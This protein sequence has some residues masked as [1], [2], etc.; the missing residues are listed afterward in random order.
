MIKLG[1][2]VI[3]GGAGFAAGYFFHQYMLAPAGY[4]T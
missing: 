3:L 4:A 1:L 2:T